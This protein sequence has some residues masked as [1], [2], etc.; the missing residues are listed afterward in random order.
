MKKQDEISIGSK[1]GCYT[2][3]GDNNT[4]PTEPIKNQMVKLNLLLK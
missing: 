1:I 3:I 2:I 4:Y